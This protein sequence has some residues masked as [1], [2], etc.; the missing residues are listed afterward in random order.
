M[1]KYLN[2]K[3]IIILAAF[4]AIFHFGI[5]LL[6]SPAISSFVVDNI[7]KYAGTK[8]YA[9]KVNAWP[10]TLS[11]GLKDLKVFDPDKDNVRIVSVK[12]VSMRLSFLGLLSK[13]LALSSADINGVQVNLEG[14][15]DGTF[16]IQKLMRPKDKK[17]ENARPALGEMFKGKQDLFVRAYGLLKDK[18]SKD[19]L[20]KQKQKNQQAKKSTKQVVSLPKG[21]IVRFKVIGGRYLIEARSVAIKSISINLKSQ[22]NREVDIDKATIEIKDIGFDPELGSRIGRFKLAGR[23]IA[24][25]IPAG[26]IEFSYVKN[27]ALKDQKAEFDFR[28]K[29]VN[30]DAVRFIYENSLPVEVVRGT[31]NLDSKTN[32]INDAIDSRNILSLS[33]HELKPRGMEMTSSGLIPASMICE[34]L[35]NINPVSLNF[36]VSGTVDKP[37]FSDFMKSLMGLVKPNL[38]SIERA[39]KN[40]G[41]KAISGLLENK[42]RDEKTQNQNT[43]N[44]KN[45]NKAGANDVIN[46]LQSI[47]DTKN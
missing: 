39:I 44:E 28:L 22:D 8:I 38:K 37:E 12:S 16:N 33:N 24:K 19:A 31:L 23:I 35:N 45:N 47:F 27:K 17:A 25:N 43:S 34:I 5:G 13:R 36:S 6:V 1:K 15:P 20:A 29:D 14:E 30:L 18:F 26:N 11:L 7:N 4:L 46:S 10:L 9:G 41:L 21:R 42:S 40:E 32:I 2:I 3:N